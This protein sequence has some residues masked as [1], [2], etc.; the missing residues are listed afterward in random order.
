MC[1]VFGSD[2]VDSTHLVCVYVVWSL[3]V[4]GVLVIGPR[5]LCGDVEDGRT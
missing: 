4:C 1:V 3:Y 2:F 5:H